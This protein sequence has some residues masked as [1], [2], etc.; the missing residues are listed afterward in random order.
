MFK[1]KDID[2]KWFFTEL[3]LP[4]KAFTLF[5]R[6]DLIMLVPLIVLILLMGFISVR[7]MT[8]MIGTYV[9]IRYAGEMIYW[10]SHQFNERRYRP[11]DIGFKKLDNNAVY[12]LYQT[13]AT[14]GAVIGA[15]ILIYALYFMK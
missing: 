6:G 9:L 1:L 10:F 8:A 14:A 13:Y 3:P 12:I 7:F 5:V 2:S 11:N 4:L 15:G